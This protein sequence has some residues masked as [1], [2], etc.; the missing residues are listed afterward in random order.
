MIY[1]LADLA[2][3]IIPGLKPRAKLRRQEFGAVNDL[4]FTL[5]RGEAVAICGRNGAG[6]TTLLRTIAGL[7][8]PA[9]GT[10]TINGRVNSIIELGRGLIP[11]L[12]GRENAR[13][14]LVWRG[15][16]LHDLP[17]ANEKLNDF[18]ELGDAFDQPVGSYSSGMR[19]RLAFAIAIS[20][21]C[22]LMLVD[23]VLAVGDLRFQHKCLTHMRGFIET[24]GSL[25]LV[26]HDLVQMQTVCQRG[27]L[28]EEG[29]LVFDGSMNEC[30]R[31]LVEL[32]E[33]AAGGSSE[34]Q[35]TGLQCEKSDEDLTQGMVD[36]ARSSIRIDD[37]T[38]LHG[39]DTHGLRTG[40]DLVVQIDYS[41]GV[42][43]EALLVCQIW[44]QDNAKCIS[45]Q[46][47][48]SPLFLKRGKGRRYCRFKGLPLL[49]GR[50]SLQTYIVDPVLLQNFSD[51]SLNMT[52]GFFI[53]ED[54]PTQLQTIRR[55][56]GELI[57]LES[58][59]CD[60]PK[61]LP[62][63]EALLTISCVEES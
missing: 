49:A 50:Y 18:A 6:K 37:V 19:S 15:V 46:A 5:E 31:R 3:D 1:G 48:P 53:K 17:Q 44:T 62:T 61:E 42:E 28:I 40:D 22:D 60:E 43:R 58:D 41:S 21:P 14:N 7:L 38:V 25:L 8:R 47:D 54:E 11:H 63:D 36:P 34:A 59:W 52:S 55:H 56:L 35:E 20:T 29:A 45:I 27:L 4:S 24:G 9:D 12:T 16:A 57:H 13:L 30:A 33:T 23:E 39:A 26:S 32:Q 10:V 2:A 51:A